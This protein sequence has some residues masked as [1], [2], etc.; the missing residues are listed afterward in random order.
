MSKKFNE[1]LDLG[2]VAKIINVPAPSS[3]GDAANKAY[4]DAAVV[5]VTYVEAP[6]RVAVTTNVNTAS[7]GASLDG[8]ALAAGNRVLL[9]AQTTP[10]QNGTWLWNGAA[11]AMTRT[12]DAFQN[13]T[14]VISGSDGS[15][16]NRDSQWMQTTDGPITVGTTAMTWVQ[17]P[18]VQ[19]SAGTGLTQTGAVISLTAPVTIALG[20]TGATTAAAALAGLGAARGTEFDIGDGAASSFTLNTA[21]S[22]M[23]Y[24]SVQVVNNSTG[25]IEDALVT[26]TPGAPTGGVYTPSVVVT[27]EAWVAV[28]PTAAAYHVTIVG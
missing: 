23:K 26:I 10:S 5:G 11:V 25:Q 16:T 24:P 15:S 27:S 9:A 22:M 14:V 20:G 13:G 4:V 8:L 3:A 6:V 28:P 17:L 21:K 2:S 12:A 18:N 7:P 19:I 1:N